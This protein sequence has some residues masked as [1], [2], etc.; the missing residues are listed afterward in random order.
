MYACGPMGRT[1]SSKVLAEVDEGLLGAVGARTGTL[2]YSQPAVQG[3]SARA[4]GW[5]LVDVSEWMS[6]LA[7]SA[8]LTL[9]VG[10]SA[11]KADSAELAELVA[12]AASMKHALLVSTAEYP[13]ST[14]EY[15]RS[16]LEY[17]RST[18]EYPRS[19]AECCSSPPSP[20]WRHRGC[21]YPKRLRSAPGVS[22]PSTPSGALQPPPTPDDVWALRGRSVSTPSTCEYL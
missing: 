6:T 10:A 13:R 15:P 20:R 11:A 5:I 2:K 12:L 9:L 14:F 7:L 22:T 17:P 3:G 8:V 18:L 21:E 16:T 4:D 19:T 1:H